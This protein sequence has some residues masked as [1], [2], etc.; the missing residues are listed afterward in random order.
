M[1]VGTDLL[2]YNVGHEKH[3]FIV[4]PFYKKSDKWEFYRTVKISDFKGIKFPGRG[5]S[6]LNCGVF[7]KAYTCDCRESKRAIHHSC[8]NINCPICYQ[9]SINRS[10][11]RVDY[12]WLKIR[13]ALKIPRMKDFKIRHFSFNTLWDITKDN[14]KF[15]RAKM[16]KILKEQGMHG[17]LFFHP[18]RVGEYKIVT[19]WKTRPDRT[20]IVKMKYMK[21]FGHFHF[22]G[23]GAPINVNLFKEKY[24]FNYSNISV[25]NYDNYKSK[26]PFIHNRRMLR[27]TIGYCLTHCG[28][29]SESHCYT[30]IGDYAYNKLVKINVVNESENV[31]CPNC[32]GSLFKI[33][34]RPFNIEGSVEEGFI[35]IFDHYFSVSSHECL[36]K[37]IKR[38]SLEFKNES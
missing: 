36:T 28:Y 6:M 30:W 7:E 20:K 13:K 37:K 16:N 5:K 17:N 8:N 32:N 23:T 1:A 35:V 19:K 18:G 31:L 9:K 11:K 21:K 14:F 38:Y 22:I 4:K 34:N 33:L 27:N 3:K 2:F 15:Y 26:Y 29:V 10:V 12:R 25:K 24:G